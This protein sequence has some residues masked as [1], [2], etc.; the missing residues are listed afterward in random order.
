[1]LTNLSTQTKILAAFVVI[2][3]ASL[4]SGG[5]TA[6]QATEV[7]RSIHDMHQK[8]ELEEQRDLLAGAVTRQELALKRFVLT[9]EADALG[10]METEREAVQ[11]RFATLQG[12]LAPLQAPELDAAYEAALKG[13]L[14]WDGQH[15]A[16][17]TGY[18]R[19]PQ[20]IDLARLGGNVGPASGASCAIR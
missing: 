17:V 9:G 2:G 1:M 11:A 13:W 15:V 16:R 6:W 14:A 18:M 4:I 8:L 19:T 3:L 5:F 12:E 10:L 20:T 7:T